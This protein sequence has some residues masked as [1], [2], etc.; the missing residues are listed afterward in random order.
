MNH[1]PDLT[2]R[3]ALMLALA[4]IAALILSVAWLFDGFR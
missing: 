1:A 4:T 2:E 3:E